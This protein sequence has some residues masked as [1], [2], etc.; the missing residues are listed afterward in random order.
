VDPVNPPAEKV[1]EFNELMQA[2]KVLTNKLIEIQDKGADIAI[3]SIIK[4]KITFRK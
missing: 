1:D 2:I 4:G 3:G